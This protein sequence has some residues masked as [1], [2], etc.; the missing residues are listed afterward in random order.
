[1]HIS[2]TQVS[3]VMEL[4]LHKVYAALPA[5][6][7]AAASRADRITLSRQATEMQQIRQAISAISD[8][9]SDVV[10]GIRQKVAAG[11]YEIN[12]QQLAQSIFSRALDGRV[13][14]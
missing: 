14:N 12:E 3:K 7:T 10:S 13:G 6:G 8:T 4:H 1:M 9:R 2:N 5:V 11:D